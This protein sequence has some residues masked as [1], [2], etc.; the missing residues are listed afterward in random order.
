VRVGG[1]GLTEVA[2]QS[3][4]VDLS[5][6]TTPGSAR[7]VAVGIA[8]GKMAVLTGAAVPAGVRTALDDQGTAGADLDGQIQRAVRV[9]CRTRAGLRHTGQGGVVAEQDRQ[10]VRRTDPPQLY[11]VP[12]QASRLDQTV[13]DHG[14]SD[15]HP[16]RH[17][18]TGMTHNHVTDRR[19]QGLDD[20]LGI[21]SQVTATPDHSAPAVEPGHGT[22]PILV[23]HVDGDHHRAPGIGRKDA[24]GPTTTTTRCAVLGQPTRRTQPRGDLGGRRAGQTQPA[25]E[26]HPS[27]TR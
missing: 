2:S 20:G 4:A 1:F 27:Q 6:P 5:A 21:A 16:D 8:E 17:H 15:R 18:A 9:R 25:G 12:P 23:A 3:A 10:P 14:A 24:G 19:P 7:A 13:V 22:P 11:R 26:L